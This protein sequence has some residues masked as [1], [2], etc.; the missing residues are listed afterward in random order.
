MQGN[1]F[2][3]T[4]FGVAPATQGSKKYVGVRR[5]VAGNNIPLIIE[6][7]PGLPKFRNAVAEACMSAMGQVEGFQPF[8]QA[9]KV[10]ATFY[11]PKAASMR[12]EYPINQ[13]SGD[14]DKYLRALL[15]SITRA[16][17][18][19]DDSLVIEVEAYKLY[20]TGEPGV[21][22]TITALN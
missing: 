18:W 15:D 17:A 21:A 1:S 2:S 12:A 20:A 9:V 13:R 7:H 19:G 4:M 3:F 11:L 14:L 16:G 5:T 10:T 22:V 8:M 6:S